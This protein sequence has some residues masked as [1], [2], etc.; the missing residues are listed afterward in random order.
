MA[1]RTPVPAPLADADLC[2]FVRSGVSIAVA[3]CDAQGRSHVVRAVGSRHDG[4]SLAVFVPTAQATAVLA[5]VAARGRVAVGFSQPSTHRTVQLK[6]EDARVAPL[7]A[8]DRDAVRAY[9]AAFAADLHSIGYGQ[10]F[11]DALLAGIDDDLVAI[12]F[13]PGA[14]FNGTPGPQAGASVDG[15]A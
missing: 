5:D 11:T 7:D 2:G 15:A 13:T 1:D 14:A 3:T 10:A 12:V 9:H 4:G 6:G 8:A